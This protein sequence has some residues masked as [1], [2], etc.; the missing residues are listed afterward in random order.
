M[1]IIYILLNVR[2]NMKIN[3]VILQLLLLI[4]LTLFSSKIVFAQIESS[5]IAISIPIKEDVESGDLICSEGDGYGKCLGERNSSIFGVV[6]DTPAASFEVE[7]DDDVRLVQSSGNVEVRVT[8]VAGNISEGKLLTSS[9]TAGVAKLAESNGYVLGTALEGFEPGDPNE[10]G[11][12]LVSINIHYSTSV[13]EGRGVNLLEDIKQAIIA[14]SLSPL[15]S[16]RYLLAFIIAIISF[17]LG[18]VYFGRVVRTG[19]EAIGR[20]PMARKMIQITM[21]FNILI[22]IVIVLAG[23]FIAYLILVL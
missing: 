14:P 6:T 1:T 23:L 8:G 9:E 17:V 15:A 2:L 13:A 21:L 12:I 18:F 10:V 22:T 11:K 3:K 19:I 16:L 5:G 4:I 20:N 7:G